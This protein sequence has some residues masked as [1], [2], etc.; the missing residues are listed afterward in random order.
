[1]SMHGMSKSVLELCWAHKF[2][3]VLS[4]SDLSLQAETLIDLQTCA[5]LGKRG[6]K[7]RQAHASETGTNR[8]YE[9]ESDVVEPPPPPSRPLPGQK[10]SVSV[11][12][13]QC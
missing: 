1:M 8:G 10:Q 6:S 9:S 4:T 13:L 5:G 3:P 2:L 11:Q 7:R 12:F